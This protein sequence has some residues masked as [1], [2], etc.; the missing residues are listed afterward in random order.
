M[1]LRH[2]HLP[3]G[4]KPTMLRRGLIDPLV[5][6]CDDLRL[7]VYGI[8]LRGNRRVKG[9]NGAFSERVPFTPRQLKP[10]CDREESVVEESKCEDA[11]VAGPALQESIA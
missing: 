8:V 9:L 4:L 1:P 7:L 11:V 10:V 3:I 2:T 5:F 6:P